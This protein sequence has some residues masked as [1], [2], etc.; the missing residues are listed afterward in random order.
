MS[1]CALCTAFDMI[2]D[3][4]LSPRHTL[5][6]LQQIA[7]G[8]DPDAVAPRL[9]D[10]ANNH[11]VETSSASVWHEYRKGSEKPAKATIPQIPRR[12]IN[13]KARAFRCGEDSAFQER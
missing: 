10:N 9:V 5:Q 12:E 1:F 13:K 11:S 6:G 2:M 8:A 4:G 7:S 3:M